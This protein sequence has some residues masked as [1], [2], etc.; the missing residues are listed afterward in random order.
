MNEIKRILSDMLKDKWLKGFL[1]MFAFDVVL[2]LA[3]IKYVFPH[4]A[5]INISILL[6]VLIV[7]VLPL[8]K[9]HQMLFAYKD[10][11]RVAL[12]KEFQKNNEV[13][14]EEKKWAKEMLSDIKLMYTS[15]EKQEALNYIKE[16]LVENKPEA[17][18]DC[19]CTNG[20]IQHY[21][22]VARN[23]HIDFNYEIPEFIHDI[24]CE[25]GITVKF[26]STVI[27]N[28]MDNAIEALKASKQNEK[29][30]SLTV[31][32]EHGLKITIKNNGPKIKSI[33][34]I[35]EPR[36]STKGMNRGLGLIAVLRSIESVDGTLDVNS[37]KEE[38]SFE[39]VI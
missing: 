27:G 28:I 3:C 20:I 1:C 11:K 33:D 32:V 17:Y 12:N 36:F 13:L 37:T 23:N 2:L 29:K 7:I 34:K 31:D 10:V 30:L 35:F 26:L 39:V 14:N 4:I 22:D 25:H 24:Y 8:Y 19:Y 18:T 5:N 21:K 15:G 16:H 6:F 9:F 38:T